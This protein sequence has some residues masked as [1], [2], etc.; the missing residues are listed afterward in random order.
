MRR[1]IESIEA[2]YKK[3]VIDPWGIDWRG[4]MQ[5]RNFFYRDFVIRIAKKYFQEKKQLV[6]LDIG[7]GSG[8]LSAILYDVLITNFPNIS[9][10]AVDISREAIERAHTYSHRDFISYRV[11]GQNFKDING[12]PF[13]LIIGLE[14]LIYFEEIEFKQFFNQLKS[15]LSSEGKIIFSSNIGINYSN[16][17][18]IDA[19]ILEKNF[20]KYFQICEIKDLYLNSYIDMFEQKFLTYAQGNGVIEKLIKIY[21]Y[22]PIIPHVIHILWNRWS[23]L[24]I[25]KKRNR[26]YLLL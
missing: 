13:D 26:A 23:T 17:A 10:H 3:S 12:G 7:C 4:S 2:F 18:Y 21:L 11:V 19:N 15:L 9:Y 6:I 14:I 25:P 20:K 22:S 5:V 8:V 16:D 24:K 1:T